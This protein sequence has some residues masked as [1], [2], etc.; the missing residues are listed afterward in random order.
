VIVAAKEPSPVKPKTEIKSSPVKTEKKSPVKKEAPPNE[1][2]T[3]SKS[4][5]NFLKK[6]EASDTPTNKDSTNISVSSSSTTT[7][8]PNKENFHPIDH[9]CWT[10]DQPVPY[11]ALAQTFYTMEQTTKRN[12]FLLNIKLLN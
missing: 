7:Y 4:M 10:K 12:S 11:S 9:A 3:I 8:Q 5:G 6:N 2:K 1:M